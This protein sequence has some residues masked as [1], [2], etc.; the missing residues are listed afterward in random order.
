MRGTA[1]KD[2]HDH[3]GL[4]ANTSGQLSEEKFAELQGVAFK[5]LSVDAGDGA[6]MDK[7][8]IAFLQS[9]TS[10][11]QTKPIEDATGHEDPDVAAAEKLSDIGVIGKKAKERL[12]SAIALA[13][14]VFEESSDPDMKGALGARLKTLTKADTA[15]AKV[16]K[17]E[18]TKSKLISATQCVKKAK[19][20]EAAS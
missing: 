7:G 18:N 17:I 9:K 3:G 5:Q 19:K 20:I 8:L 16:L 1:Y 12:T 15:G 14:K 11:G 6:N 13:Q 4:K 2:D 10:P